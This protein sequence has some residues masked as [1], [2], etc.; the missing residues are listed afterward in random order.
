M[1]SW[2]QARE[3]ALFIRHCLLYPPD[4]KVE[5]NIPVSLRRKQTECR[6]HKANESV[7]TE[8]ARLCSRPGTQ[9]REGGRQSTCPPG[10]TLWNAAS[11]EWT[12]G[13]RSRACSA[14]LLTFPRQAGPCSVSFA[15]SCRVFRLE[16]PFPFLSLAM[17][18]HPSRTISK[19]SS[20]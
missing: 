18:R 3:G 15:C 13:W 16:C 1:Q 8:P 4:L 11:A 2:Y 6:G 19:V 5:D 7:N 14:G 17:S 10:T 20:P 12:V 9:G